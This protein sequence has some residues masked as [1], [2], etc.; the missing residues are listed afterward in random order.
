MVSSFLLFFCLISIS[1]ADLLAYNASSNAGLHLIK[2]GI[3]DRS[4]RIL[5]NSVL[6]DSEMKDLFSANRTL[7]GKDANGTQIEQ[8]II[9]WNYPNNTQH[10]RI[11]NIDLLNFTDT[12]DQIISNTTD[13]QLVERDPGDT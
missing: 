13:Y 5:S 1:L 11:T 3:T 6:L 9:V 2:D 4:S 12:D 10:I 8:K 7:Y